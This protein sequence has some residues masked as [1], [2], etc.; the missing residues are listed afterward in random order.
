MYLPAAIE[1]TPT[2]LRRYGE[3]DIHQG[4]A[5]VGVGMLHF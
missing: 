3:G 5:V 2:L 1:S 4:N